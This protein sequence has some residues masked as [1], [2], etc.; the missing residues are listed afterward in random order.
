MII[1]NNTE[2]ILKW[3]R[4]VQRGAYCCW[5]CVHLH[6]CVWKFKGLPKNGLKHPTPNHT[7]FEKDILI[8]DKFDR[9][10]NRFNGVIIKTWVG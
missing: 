2:E 3:E 10:S 6:K 5:K 8:R 7:T 9:L 1:K 4:A